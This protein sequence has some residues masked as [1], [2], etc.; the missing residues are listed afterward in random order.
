MKLELVK[1]TPEVIHEYLKKWDSL[2]KYQLH[3]KSLNE[4]F[5]VYCQNNIDLY[6]IILK[7]SALNDFYSTN[8]LDTYSVA[9]HIHSM[10]IDER[11]DRSDLSLVNQIAKIKI[12]D[13]EINFYSFATKYCSHHYPDVYPIYDSFVSKMLT[14]YKKK[15]KFDQF[16]LVDMKNYEKFVRVVY[17]FRQF[18]KLEEFT[19]RQI[20]IFLWILGKEFKKSTEI[21]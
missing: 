18:Y 12:K 13:K 6:K 16:T 17:N 5:N 3:E 21:S 14:A 11:L 15:D 1:P 10:N 8:I 9:L 4:L 2:V 7:V 19:I 20:D